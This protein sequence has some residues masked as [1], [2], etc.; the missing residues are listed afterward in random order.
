MK[1]AAII[2]SVASLMPIMAS[3]AIDTTPFKMIAVSDNTSIN[4]AVLKATE[5]FFFIGKETNSTCGDVDPVLAMGNINGTLTMYHSPAAN[6]SQ[7]AYIDISGVADGLFAYSPQGYKS[8]PNNDYPYLNKF[9]RVADKLY[10]E[11]HGWLACSGTEG[12]FWVY[13][14]SEYGKPEIYKKECIPF[15]IRIEEVANATSCEYFW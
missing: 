2:A 1:I 11:G 5:R 3:A 14:E 6:Y 13:S 12:E 15:D 7:T 10:Y 9:S 4:G 8:V